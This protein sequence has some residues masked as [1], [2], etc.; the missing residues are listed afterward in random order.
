MRFKL[1][2]LCL[3]LLAFNTWAASSQLI[4]LTHDYSKSTLHWP[5]STAFTV[6]KSIAGKMPAGF[7]CAVR[8]FAANEHA[9][10]HMDAPSHFA[11]G[12]EGV[13]DVPLQNLTGPAIKVDVVE[14]VKAN[15]DYLITIEDF[16]KW[17]NAHGK[18]PDNTI[19]LLSTG[20]GDYW[21]SASRYTGTTKKG[22]ASLSDLHF[23]GLDPKAARWLVE[24]RKI[25]A[26][27][28]DTFSIDY[29]QT[30]QFESHQI[31]TQH[32]VP[33]FENVASMAELPA[34][35][36]VVYAFP[37]KIKNGTGAPLRIVAEVK[38]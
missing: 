2:A 8:D 37:M 6:T 9:G 3:S 28:I 24:S 35:G 11:K 32:D 36:F 27:G 19:V 1:S 5:T 34:A 4:D 31:L 13:S 23:P 33:I 30:K 14:K 29:G 17:E 21:S 12:H 26:V 20:Y 25:K 18:I 16:E 15:K 10:T 7:Y 38:A 22:A